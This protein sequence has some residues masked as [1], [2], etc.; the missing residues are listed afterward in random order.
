MGKMPMPRQAATEFFSWSSLRLCAFA[1]HYFSL[2]PSPA[3]AGYPPETEALRRGC[4]C[5]CGKGHP[6]E[7]NFL[8]FRRPSAAAPT[9][10]RTNAQEPMVNIAPEGAGGS[11]IEAG[12]P[13]AR[14]TEEAGMAT[15]SRF[16]V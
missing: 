6:E 12:A 9:H 4:R 14:F 13:C 10:A 3:K 8:I 16:S 5:L 15:G 1:L 7:V 11:L 2:F